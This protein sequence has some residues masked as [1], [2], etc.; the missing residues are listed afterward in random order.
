MD[1]NSNIKIVPMLSSLLLLLCCV[2]GCA[3]STDKAMHSSV[4]QCDP[5]YGFRPTCWRQ[6][7]WPVCCGAGLSQRWTEPTVERLPPGES[8]PTPPAEPNATGQQPANYPPPMPPK[9]IES[10]PSRESG[11]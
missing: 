4:I 11:P 3:S 6:Q 7:P 2:A 10:L 8:I 1:Q 9:P 5:A